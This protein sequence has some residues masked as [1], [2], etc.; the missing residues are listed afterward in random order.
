[1]TEMDVGWPVEFIMYVRR[2]T[3]WPVAFNAGIR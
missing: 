1:M 2:D 3:F